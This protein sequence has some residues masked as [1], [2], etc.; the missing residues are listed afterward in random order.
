MT[1]QF[2]MKSFLVAGDLISIKIPE[3][4]RYTVNTKCHGLSFWMLGA[5]DCKLS[6]NLDE[7]TITVKVSGGYSLRRLQQQ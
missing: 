1:W 7:V 6:N 4:F 3:P 5:L 2:Q